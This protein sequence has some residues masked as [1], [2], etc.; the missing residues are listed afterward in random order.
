MEEQLADGSGPGV[1][2]PIKGTLRWPQQAHR[3]QWLFCFAAPGPQ[4]PSLLCPP[5]HAAALT[6][7]W[8]IEGQAP[9]PVG[10]H[11]EL[12]TFHRPPAGFEPTGGSRS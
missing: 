6:P 12:Q 11:F 3:L 1:Y 7:Q 4:S 2:R 9:C 10:A 8:P 5:G